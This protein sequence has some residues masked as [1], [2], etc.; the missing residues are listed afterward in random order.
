MSS[1]NENFTYVF[2]PAN[3]EEPIEAREGDKSGGLSDDILIKTAKDYFFQQSGG[4]SRAETLDSASPEERKVMAQQIRAQV[5]A[6][7]PNAESQMAKMDDDAL[8]SLVRYVLFG[9]LVC[10]ENASRFHCVSFFL[11]DLVRH[12]HLHHVKSLH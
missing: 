10:C 11:N 5:K 3:E 2:I 9:V 8:L 7:S 12:T 1:L 6:G 4:D